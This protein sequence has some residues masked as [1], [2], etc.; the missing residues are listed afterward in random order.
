[1][2]PL[3]YSHPRRNWLILVLVGIVMSLSLGLFSITR[4]D[5]RAQSGP[6]ISM[7]P[8]TLGQTQITV[9]ITGTQ[10]PDIAGF[11]FDLLSDPAVARPVTGTLGSLLGSTG[12]ITGLLGPQAAPLSGTLGMGGYVY[13]APTA[14]SGAG[15]LATI[16][17]DVVGEG[18]SRLV[19]SNTIFAD[20]TATPFD[21]TLVDGGVQAKAMQAGWQM[22]GICVDVSSQDVQGALQSID[23]TYERVL[24]EEG[25]Y[26]VDLP[27]QFSTLKAFTT[28]AAYWIRG[29]EEVTLTFLGDWWPPN[30]PISLHQG[31]NWVG[32]CNRQS[33]AV[34][35]ALTSTD[36]LY[37]RILGDDGTYDTTVPPQFNTLQTLDPGKGYLLYMTQAATLTYPSAVTALQTTPA[38]STPDTTLCPDLVRTPYFSEI[39]GQAD[40]AAAGQILRAYDPRG[41]LAGCAQVRADGS[42]GLMRLYG[43]KD[44][45]DCGR[46]RPCASSWMVG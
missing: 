1:M 11:E 46:V 2:K 6:T 43:G 10:L 5:A 19:F 30:T 13:N 34:T 22:V 29:S 7:V 18:I 20:P 28:G 21:V 44:A 41:R 27:P 42:Y 16:D 38:Q 3:S 17:I 45:N 15:Q 33:Q 35:N 36:G 8:T 24:G 39:Y 12:G 14:P 9:A 40:P 37:T 23:G 31:W 4:T 26:V 25:S 32:F